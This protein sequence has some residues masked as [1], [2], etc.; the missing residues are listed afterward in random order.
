VLVEEVRDGHGRVS[1]DFDRVGSSFLPVRLGLVEGRLAISASSIPEEAPVGSVITMIDGVPATDRIATAMRLASGSRQWKEIRAVETIETGPAGSVVTMVIGG[2]STTRTI[3]LRRESAKQPPE[4]R[5]AALVELAPDTWYLDLTRVRWSEVTPYLNGLAKAANVIFDV[6]GYPTD[7]GVKILP[8][9][10]DAAEDDHWMHTPKI[11]EPF[12]R[13][14]NWADQGWAL[15]PAHPHFSGRRI[16]L[17]DARAISYA[18]SVM[19]YVADH[20]LGIII[21]SPTAGANGNIASFSLPGRF[22]I[23]LTGMRITAHDGHT[24]RHVTGIQPDIFATPTIV[25]ISSG[26]DD[27]LEKALGVARTQR[28]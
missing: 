4:P 18:E 23:S 16:F 22:T 3:R 26:R 1:D 2:G 15:K 24:S 8:Y 20:K 12:G 19:G 13:F 11:V 17:T 25:G 21:G 5:P 28:P 27:V 6:R 7:A 14:T 10:L 9:L